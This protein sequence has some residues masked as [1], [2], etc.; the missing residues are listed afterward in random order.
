MQTAVAETTEFY[1][2][3]ASLKLDPK[4]RAI[5]GQYMTPVPI[6][7]FMASLFS[8]ARGE[9]RLLDAG[10]GVGSLTA[11]FVEMLCKRRKNPR[12]ASL[13]CYE[14]EPMLLDYL[15]NTLAEA[16]GQCAG[17]QIAAS[18]EINIKCTA[19]ILRPG[20][21]VMPKSLLAAW[22]AARD[23]GDLYASKMVPGNI[24]HEIWS[25]IN[26][27]AEKLGYM[28]VGPDSGGD[29]VTTTA[30][31]VGIYGHSLGNNAHDIGARI[32]A[33]LPFAYGERV[34]FPLV[35]NE[36]VSI[37]LHV[38]TSIPEWDG[39]TWYARFEE[40]AQI[41]DEGVRWLVP[42]QEELF[43]IEPAG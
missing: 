4:K 2:V 21:T 8:D 1:R 3:D 39:Q 36:W 38:S 26:A 42:T 24:G 28:P 23:M 6:G 18:S 17:V 10:A 7:H 30:P 41:T 13:V 5:L 32:A 14:I 9:I 40:T 29:A 20:E 11:A 37:E 25:T 43:L 12:S 35:A 27:E 16:V 22:R 33:D 34:R 19:Y 31:E 15:T